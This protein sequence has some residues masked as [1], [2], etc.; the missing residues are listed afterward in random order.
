MEMKMSVTRFEAE[1]IMT[2]SSFTLSGFGNNVAGDAKINGVDA[3]TFR[4]QHNNVD[5]LFYFDKASSGIG[6]SG[7]I[8]FDLTKID[9]SND[10]TWADKMNGVW[11]Y[12]YYFPND[13]TKINGVFKKKQ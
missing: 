1:D 8:G 10:A 12:I 3:S 7:N 4:S 6:P 2:A 13:P 5:Y 9:S 11:E